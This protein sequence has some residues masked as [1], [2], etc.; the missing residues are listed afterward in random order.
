MKAFSV[1][2]E[3]YKVRKYMDFVGMALA[4]QKVTVVPLVAVDVEQID[5][6]GQ[7]YMQLLDLGSEE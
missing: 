2:P 1:A 3:V 6:K 4:G 7:L 5:L